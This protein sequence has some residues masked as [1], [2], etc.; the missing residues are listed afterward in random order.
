MRR[1][2]AKIKKIIFYAITLFL[3]ASNSYA[4][5]ICKNEKERESS[6]IEIACLM[7]E[8]L[9]VK[10]E[11]AM[12]SSLL[13]HWEIDKELCKFSSTPKYDIFVEKSLNNQDI[14]LGK[15]WIESKIGSNKE[16]MD[17]YSG[18]SKVSHC[19][20]QY[21]AYGPG[22]ELSFFVKEKV[23][24]D[25]S[26]IRYIT[27]FLLSYFASFVLM[28]FLLYGGQKDK[29]W[30]KHLFEISKTSLYLSILLFVTNIFGCSD[31]VTRRG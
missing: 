24:L 2:L 30:I 12:I 22:S 8:E 29:G 11:V 1:I 9:D 15:L 7:S 17:S 14:T 13:K 23:M 26:I 27:I 5:D 16:I 19:E 28:F 21:E 4:S 10:M 6:V 31:D 3:I 18:K 25:N 20:K